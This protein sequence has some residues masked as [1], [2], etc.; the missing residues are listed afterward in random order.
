[1]RGPWGDAQR[2]AVKAQ[3]ERRRGDMA[4]QNDGIPPPADAAELSP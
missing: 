1:M 3:C 4:S 2:R